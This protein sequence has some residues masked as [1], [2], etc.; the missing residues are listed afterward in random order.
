[1]KNL[2]FI[3]IPLLFLELLTLSCN[4][5]DDNSGNVDRIVGSWKISDVRVDDTSVYNV[6][7]NTPEGCFLNSKFHFY[8]D[9]TF[10]TN[11]YEVNFDNNCVE[12]PEQMGTWS[13]DGDV[14]TYVLEGESPNSQTVN[15]V[16]N[17]QFYYTLT[18][19]EFTYKIYLSR[20]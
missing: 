5:D 7:I 3:F 12:Q 4:N 17:N 14:Y 1:M 11:P 2:G 18:V 19:E 9:Y 10:K 16:N 15:F 6:L 8:N 20:M 13:R